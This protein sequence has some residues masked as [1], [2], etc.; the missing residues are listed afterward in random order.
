MKKEITIDG[1]SIRDISTF[2]TEINSVFMHEET[3]EIAQSLDAFDDLLYGGYGAINGNEPVR[4][5]WSNI[6]V[7][8]VALGYETTKSYYMRKL[9]QP[10]VFNTVMFQE[11]LDALDAGVGETYFDIIIGIIASHPNIELVRL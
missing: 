11:K 2:Y 8:L 4:L 3:W 10:A 9:E 1:G 7:S 5:I 6:E